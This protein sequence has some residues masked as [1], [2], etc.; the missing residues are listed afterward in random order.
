MIARHD[1]AQNEKAGRAVCSEKMHGMDRQ[2]CGENLRVLEDAERTEQ[3]Q[4]AEPEH[5]DGT[6]QFADGSSAV[7]LDDE[8]PHQNAQRKRH[9]E[10]VQG[11]RAH[12]QP[13]DGGQHGDSRRNQGIPEEQ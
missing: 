11:R 13:F 3:A 8:Q 5:H 9:D 2:Q 4:H 12:F 6:E 1:R 10:R 7:L